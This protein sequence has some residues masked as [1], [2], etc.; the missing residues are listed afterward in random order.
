MDCQMPEMDGYEATACIRQ[1]EQTRTDLHR[2]V[3]IIAMTANALQ[4]D[5]EKCLAAGMDDYI[6]KQETATAL[7][8]PC[9]CHRQTAAG[10]GRAQAV[11]FLPAPPG[12]RRPSPH[13]PRRGQRG[14]PDGRS[15]ISSLPV[16]RKRH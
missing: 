12:T 15:D 8:L 4:G 5:R 6:G 2:P 16:S 9:V 13:P 3:S 14:E 10:P 7:P 1:L 11:R